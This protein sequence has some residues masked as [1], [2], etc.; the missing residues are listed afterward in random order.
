MPQKVLTLSRKVDECK[1][2]WLPA[3][4]YRQLYADGEVMV[5][6][7]GSCGATSTLLVYERA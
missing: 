6:E 5:A 1:I 2:P 7:A 4:C 3:V